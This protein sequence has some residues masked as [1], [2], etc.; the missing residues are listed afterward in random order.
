MVQFSQKLDLKHSEHTT[1]IL[2]T[3][4]QVSDDIRTVIQAVVSNVAHFKDRE[5]AEQDEIL[6][7]LSNAA[8]GSFL[9]A[10]LASEVLRLQKTHDDFNAALQTLKADLKAISGVVTKLLALMKLSESSRLILSWLF[11]AER[12]LTLHE[13]K[14][15]LRVK[16]GHDSLSEQHSVV[17]AALLAVAPFVIVKEGLVSPRHSAME[18]AMISIPN[19]HKQ[20]LHLTE[21]HRDLVVRLLAYTNACSMEKR[22]PTLDM[23]DLALADERFDRHRLLEYTVRYWAVHFEKSTLFKPAGALQL[24]PEL[25]S[26]FPKSVILALMERACWDKQFTSIETLNLH[27]LAY[28]V[29]VA[30]FGNDH[31]CVLQ[32]SIIYASL[33]EANGRHPE[34]VTCFHGAMQMSEKLLGSQA[35]VTLLLCE[36][37]IRISKV[38]VTKTRTEIM[39]YREESYKLMVKIYTHRYG[40]SSKEVLEIYN[41]LYKLYI[42]ISDEK[43]ASAI[44]V[45]IRKITVIVHGQGSEQEREISRHLDVVLHKRTEVEVVG[46]FGGLLF[47]SVEGAVEEILT[48]AQIEFIIRRAGEFVVLKEFAQAEELYIALWLKLTHHCHTVSSVEWHEKKLHVMLIYVNFLQERKRVSEATSILVC[49]WREYEHR[50]FFQFESIIVLFKEVAVLMKTFGLFAFALSIFQK[51]RSW[52]MSVDKTN[53][54]VFKQIEIHITETSV[55]IVK[56]TSVSTTSVIVIREVFESSFNSTEISTTTIELCKSL[57]SIYIKKEQWSEALICIERTLRVSWAA[58]FSETIEVVKLTES[59]TSESIELVA[60]LAIC[61]ISRSRFERAE[62]VYLRLWK[63]IKAS[64]RVASNQF[65]EYRDIVL[66]FY[67]AHGYY[68]KLICFEQDLLVSYRTFYGAGHA[69]TIATLYTL[70]ELCLKYQRTHGFWFEYYL[71]ILTVLNKDTVICHEDALRALIVV[72]KYYYEDCRYSES[73]QYFRR[74][75]NTFVKFGKTYKFFEKVV[76]VQEIFDFYFRALEESRTEISIQISILKEF[77]QICI[78]VYGEKASIT[79]HA[80]LQ[81]AET[82]T[83]SEHFQFEAIAYYEHVCKYSSSTEII[84]KTK[85]TFKTLYIKQVTTTTVVTKEV[86]ERTTII[87]YENYVEIRKLHSCT[88]ELTLSV[89]RWSCF[90]IRLPCWRSRSRS[91]AQLSLS[92]SRKSSPPKS[93]LILRRFWPRFSKVARTRSRPGPSSMKSSCRSSTSRRRMFLPAVSTLPPLAENALPLWPPLNAISASI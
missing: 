47:G 78:N 76:E 59:F 52:Y 46:T 61:Y 19:S 45:I 17:E 81:L 25:K 69:V 26:T 24:T 15:L 55:E 14:L 34:A 67:S 7:Q 51:C 5:V 80:T 29:R 6:H 33:L 3:N 32:S 68:Q 82:C 41:L 49:I 38:L 79:I 31:A 66:A 39:I 40:A 83:R 91:S 53:L 21:R 58:F 88:H 54:A 10:S 11:A 87:C 74:L 4:D 64:Y 37:V 23:I 50:E 56:T 27:H 12:P 36:T 43:N 13:I 85:T 9:W 57:V 18:R 70:G 92:V 65:A 1:S 20:S 62:Y 84:T 60:K 89:L 86:L 44:S 75:L 22:Q 71:E 2:L 35:A 90:T 72:A 16:P 73:L 42:F 93:C 28:R 77:R 8:D 30:C 63:A 48:F